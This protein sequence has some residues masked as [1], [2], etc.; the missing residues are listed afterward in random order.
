MSVLKESLCDH[1]R[2]YRNI[3]FLSHCWRYFIN[4]YYRIIWLFRLTGGCRNSLIRRLL[5][6]YYMRQCNKFQIVLG[7]E[8][9]IGAGLIFGHN[10]PIVI[11]ANSVIGENCIIHPCVLIGGDR[12]SGNPI[13]GDNVFIGHGSKI[14]GGCHIGNDVFIAPAA[15]ITKDVPDDSIV[16]AGLNN[17]IRSSG[18]RQANMKYRKY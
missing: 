6:T 2:N 15:V 10:G 1:V 7:A 5:N 4:P 12:G 8:A 17:I 3:S 9:K 16:G 14:T 13:I 18:G 11:N